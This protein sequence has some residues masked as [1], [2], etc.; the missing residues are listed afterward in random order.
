MNTFSYFIFVKIKEIKIKMKFSITKLILISCL[1]IFSSNVLSSKIQTRVRN[2]D[3]T[4]FDLINEPINMNETRYPPLKESC[5]PKENKTIEMNATYSVNITVTNITQPLIIIPTSTPQCNEKWNYA[6]KGED[7]ECQCAEGKEQSPIDLPSKGSAT[8]APIRPVFNYE[9]VTPA[10]DSA[11]IDKINSADSKNGVDNTI[12]IRYHNGVIKIIA[13]NF[14]KLVKIDGSWYTAEEIQFHTPS[15]HTINGERM[16]MEMHIIHYGK[17]QGDIA[18]Q[19]VLSFLFKKT[20]GKYNKFIDSLD[21]YSLPNPTDN[22]REIY[23]DIYIPNVLYSSNDDEI[24]VM[25]PFSFY[26]YEGSLSFPPCT[27]RTTY[28]VSA[29]PIELSSTA[30]SLFKEA[31]RKPDSID[32]RGNIVIDNGAVTEN[33]REVQPLNNREIFIYDHLKYDCPKFAKKARKVDP[34]G[35]Y[36]KKIKES[37]QF[38]F[39]NSAEPS[40]IPGAFVVSEQEAKGIEEKEIGEDS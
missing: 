11:T 2:M 25:K 38:I 4:I 31:L 23:N 40:G 17:S 26:T 8:A 10:D 35:H 5:I 18:K 32:E 30:I 20:P 15:E 22:Y 28:Y 21:F 27:E 39:V 3:R 36:E 12:K 9:I 37:T 14:G 29:D 16:D 7:W 33:Y 19:V 13:Q 6:Q 34:Q 1:L 24:P